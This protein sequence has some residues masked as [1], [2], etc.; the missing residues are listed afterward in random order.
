MIIF[1][2]ILSVMTLIAMSFLAMPLA[3]HF[4]QHTRVTKNTGRNTVYLLLVLLPILAVTLYLKLGA[5][6]EVAKQQEILQKNTLLNEE[7]KKLGSLQN[8]ILRL[9]QQVEAHPDSEGWA[10]LGRL[11]L[12]TEQPKEASYAFAQAKRRTPNQANNVASYKLRTYITLD[13][14]LKKKIHADETLFVYAQAVNGPPMP[15]AI[16]RKQARDLPLTIILD[17]SMAMTP[18]VTLA[19]YS[20]VKITARISKS[21]QAVPAKGDLVGS[22]LVIDVA[23]PPNK[24]VIT[25]NKELR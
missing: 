16:V 10:L 4:S 7:I 8:I 25:I 12:K 5:S 21:G 18:E 13:K 6:Q 22:S 9:R 19:N 17:E 3:K 1:W 23:H 24:I 15:L 2:L 14:S 11:Y 20:Q